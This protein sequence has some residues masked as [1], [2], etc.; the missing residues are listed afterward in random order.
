MK[1]ENYEYEI[2][3]VQD[4]KGWTLYTKMYVKDFFGFMERSPKKIGK[5][6]FNS[7]VENYLFKPA[8]FCSFSM[9][10]L[11]AIAKFMEEKNL[12]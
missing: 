11:N 3:G 5:I 2:I 12:K 6:K 7:E 10:L 8:L 1:K 4:S 9:P